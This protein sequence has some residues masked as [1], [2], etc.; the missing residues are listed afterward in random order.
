MTATAG[1][2]TLVELL[3]A[4]GTDALSF[5]AV[6]S[7]VERWFDERPPAGTGACVAYCDTGSAW[8]AVCSPLVD[9][10]ERAR[11]ALRFVDAARGR[12]RRASFFAADTLDGEGL[13]R[14]LIGMQPILRPAQWLGSLTNR[15]SFREQLRRARAKGLRVRSAEASEFAVGMPARRAVDA[16]ARRWLDSRHMRPMGFVVSVEPFHHPEEHRYVVGE[17]RGR[18]VGFLSAVPIARGRGWLVEDVFRGESAPNGTTETLIHELIRSV[19]ES[20]YVTL[21]PT[22]LAG[23]VGWP[24]R[25][26]RLLAR[27]LF[28]FA[29]LYAF[30]QRLRPT[31]WQPVWLA[32]P[33]TQS[34]PVAVIDVLRAFARGSLLRFAGDSLLLHPSGLPMAVAWPLPLWTLA[35]AWLAATGRA[36]LLGFET[37]ELW[38]WVAFDA[39]LLV[40]LVRAAMQPRRSRLLLAAGL[41]AID[42]G[43][44]LAHAAFTGAGAT[45]LGHTLR[46]LATAAPVAGTVALACACVIEARAR[47]RSRP[48]S[49]EA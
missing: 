48:A 29:G 7:G 8:V 34:A 4:H 47:A 44:S 3:H 5:T 12:G 32:F 19:P 24:L 42:A 39:L 22:P 41:A 10:N 1:I 30:R 25:L 37:A 38:A 18:I 17:H 46:A 45:V 28:D 9:A 35:L 27:P 11:A 6:E 40:F 33:R 36:S 14:L 20:E 49:A 21:G 15:R 26:A 23:A 2:P 13:R 16:L 31:A 43:L